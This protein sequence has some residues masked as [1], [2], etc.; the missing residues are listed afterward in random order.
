MEC[1]A[2]RDDLLDVL[3]GEADTATAHRFNEHQA[4]CPACRD[5]LASFRH[6]RHEL[7]GWAVAP[8]RRLAFPAAGRPLR[9]LAAAAGLVATLGGAVVLARGEIRYPNGQVALRLAAAEPDT[10]E[11]R[12]LLA[13]QDARHQRALA[14]LKAASAVPAASAG[15]GDQAQLLAEIRRLV[16][17]SETRQAAVF[18]AGL[19]Q[20]ETRAQAQRRVD[21]AQV[22]AGLSY[23]EGKTGL[24]AAR[25]TELMGKVLLASQAGR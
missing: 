22:G 4:R 16:K 11:L 25:T 9:W 7:D 8:K 15:A 17:E 3:Y 6:V 24:Q 21:L 14:E 10:S 19:S 2:F 18:N 13:E 20:L 1:D 5:E 12:R 23:L